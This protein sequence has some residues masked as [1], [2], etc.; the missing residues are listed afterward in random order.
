MENASKALL[1][2]GAILIGVIIITIAVYIFSGAADLSNAYDTE[3]RNQAVASFNANFDQFSERSDL[4]VHDIITALNFAKEY[5]ASA[6]GKELITVA[7]GGSS[8]MSS[9]QNTLLNEYSLSSS[10]VVQFFTC[11]SIKYNENTGRVKSINF[12]KIP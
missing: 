1:M 11:K 9:D 4:T 10:Q 7:I 5:N 12:T 8:I 2:A 3:Q 6:N